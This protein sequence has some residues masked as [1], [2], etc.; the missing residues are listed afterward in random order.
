MSGAICKPRVT[1]RISAHK[2]GFSAELR[3]VT[4]HN[5]VMKQFNDEPTQEEPFRYT[6][7]QLTR[8]GDLQFDNRATRMGLNL[9]L[10]YPFDESSFTWSDTPDGIMAS[11]Y[12]RN[13]NMTTANMGDLI[14]LDNGEIKQSGDF[15]LTPGQ[16]RA[17]LSSIDINTL[18]TDAN[19]RP[20]APE[21][22]QAAQERMQAYELTLARCIEANA[23]QQNK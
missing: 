12:R 14:L 8:K 11:R 17:T 3:G 2:T 9:S 22:L 7:A 4:C 10:M 19:L 21:R 20:S 16:V 23:Q 18:A 6:N 5:I 1:T 15:D 13:D